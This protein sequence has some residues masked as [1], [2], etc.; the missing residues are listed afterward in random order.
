MPN[1]LNPEHKF[2]LNVRAL[3][4]DETLPQLGGGQLGVWIHTE[5][6]EDLMWSWTPEGKWSPTEVSSL[7][8]DQ[9]IK[10]LSHKYSFSVSTPERSVRGFC[11]NNQEAPEQQVNDKSLN[12]LRKEFFENFQIEF[13]TR[14]F[15][16]FN[17]F[18]YKKI[19][20]KTNE[21]FKLTDQVHKDRNYVIEVFFIPNSNYNK[22][23]LID[24]ISL[25]DSTLRYEAGIST[26][27]GLETSG[28]P[29]RPFVKEYKYELDKEELAG[30]LS[31]Y[32]G[33]TGIRAGENTTALASRDASVTS[34]TLEVSGGS[35]IS[36]RV[37][38]EW[39][40]HT[41][42]PNGSYSVVEFDN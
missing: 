11:L 29:L 33:L 15:T 21:Q 13:D 32:N 9:V 14:N 39:V 23:L 18:E 8:I 35:R 38:P 6:A 36:Y 41:D 12:N 10:K 25:E 2:K 27:L 4:A 24:S 37:Q 40:N 42:G 31:F 5:P 3:V 28:I 26:G 34:G 19:I 20:P 7:N 17:N 1:I 16:I 22:Y 30:V